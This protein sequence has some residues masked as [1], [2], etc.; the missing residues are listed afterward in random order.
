MQEK[1]IEEVKKHDDTLDTP[2]D[3]TPPAEL[4]A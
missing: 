3:F 1:T 2:A 4:Y